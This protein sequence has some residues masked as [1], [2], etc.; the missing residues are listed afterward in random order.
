M[1]TTYTAS[2]N[3]SFHAPQRWQERITR[4]QRIDGLGRFWRKSWLDWQI[5]AGQIDTEMKENGR[6]FT[7][8]QYVLEVTR[9]YHALRR[10]T[11]KGK[12]RA[13]QHLS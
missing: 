12:R 4:A 11:T 6:R 2:P 3:S 7:P 1:N 9:L 8:K 5:A 13:Q 10:A